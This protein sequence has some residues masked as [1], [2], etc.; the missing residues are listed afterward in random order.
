MISNAPSMPYTAHSERRSRRMFLSSLSA[1]VGTSIIIVIGFLLSRRGI[2]SKK[3]GE[4]LSSIV[5]SVALPC[6]ILSKFQND[7]SI[8]VFTSIIPALYA[9]AA[10]IVLSILLGF[11]MGKI[12]RIPVTRIG[13][14]ISSVAFSNFGFIGIP[15]VDAIF[16][17]KG[18]APMMMFYFLQLIVVNTVGIMLTKHDAA[19]ISGAGSRR[20]AGDVLKGLLSP[21]TIAIVVSLVLMF[22]GIKLPKVI[23]IAV[24][25]MSD[26]T[27]PLALVFVGNMVFN[28]GFKN[29]KPEKGVIEAVVGRLILSSAI[30]IGAAKFFGVTGTAFLVLTLE[31]A[32]SCAAQPATISRT[33]GADTEYTTKILIYSIFGSVITVPLVMMVAEMLM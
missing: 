4:M 22:A 16:G 1:V 2:I 15:M 30:M 5:M 20:T 31:M 27:S 17:D 10:A 19:A 8:E 21:P 33:I 7:C 25:C 9:S 18:S 12:I 3:G 26:L 13:Q 32:L 28:M 14:F 23:M 29:M 6:M 11:I 24:D